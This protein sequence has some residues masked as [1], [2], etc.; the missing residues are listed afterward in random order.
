LSRI[1]IMSTF[2]FTSSARRVIYAMSCLLALAACGDSKDVDEPADLVDFEA[3]LD[4]KRAWSY[5]FGGD[6]DRLRLAL[7]PAIA[8]GVA[9][10]IGYNGEIAA[11]SADSG[12]RIWRAKTDLPLSAGP[13]VGEGVVIAGATDGTLIAL[14]S[15]DGSERWR[16]RLSSEVLATPVVAGDL[17]LIRT[18]DGRLSALTLDKPEV[19]WA[20][21]QAVPRLSL[22]GTAPPTV[23]GD[24]V[25]AGFDN[26]RVV[27]VELTTGDTQW[28]TVVS[29]PR[30]R[31][32]LERLIDID[33][34]VRAAGE[35]IL[36][37]GFQGRVAMV[38]RDSGQIW[39]ARDF[40]SYRGFVLQDDVMYATGADGVV[41][42]MRRTDGSV[43]WEQPAMKLRGLSGPA[44]DGS[45]LVVGDFDGYLHWLNLAD[46][47]IVA[48]KS[49]GGERI[50][51]TPVVADGRVY[52]QND[53][54][55]LY[56][57]Q[58]KPKG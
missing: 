23:A 3:Q 24:T 52:V 37:M 32:E 6:S 9:Y 4:V 10:A 1:V 58:T 39:W 15:K 27:A 7:R 35:D 48:R 57:F 11:L 19:K 31:N 36:V 14:E 50:T 13:A 54:G 20:V 47:A 46:G 22:R 41:V 28:D 5:G 2:K 53:S 43:I 18:V 25:Y 12:K 45:T 56:A 30:G 49:A 51:N 17:V 29:T 34:P 26:G 33:S 8:D 16:H 42:A 55:K 44:I 40:S 21:E 38:A